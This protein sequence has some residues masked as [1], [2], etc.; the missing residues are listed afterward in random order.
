ME[1]LDFGAEEIEL[2]MESEED[3]RKGSS[4]NRKKRITKAAVLSGLCTL[5]GIPPV[6]MPLST[7]LIYEAIYGRRHKTKE[8]LEFTA[9]DF[10]NL[11]V[12]RSD[13]FETEKKKTKIAGY[14]YWKEDGTKKKGVVVVAHGLGHGGHNSYIPF[15][16]YFASNGY[17]VFTYDIRGNDNSQGKTIKG[18]PQGVIDLDCAIKHLGEVEEYKG[19]PIM[20]FGHSW[21]AFSVGNVLNLHPEVDAA[22]IIAGFNESEDTMQYYSGK[23]FGPF[24]EGLMTYVEVY[25]KIKFGNKVTSINSIDGMNGTDALILIAHS[26][27]DKVIPIKYGYDKFYKEFKDDGR[28]TFVLYEDKG[29]TNILYSDASWEYQQRL[30]EDYRIYLKESGAKDT[31][32]NK[33]GYMQYNLDKRKCYEPNMELMS[34]ILDM[35]NKAS[36]R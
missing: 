17:Y 23:A 30:N 32:R 16:D 12:E 13:F 31:E 7:V 20:L 26:K 19:L 14:K 36:K 9:E 22:A 6:T 10:D 15:V 5:V 33:L 18:I 25:E 8:W 4:R 1:E 28:F 29:H 27:D 11:S 21:G 35:Y 24:S 34:K 2:E 3:E